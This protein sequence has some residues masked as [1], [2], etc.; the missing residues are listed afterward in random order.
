MTPNLARRFHAVNPPSAIVRRELAGGVA[1]RGASRH[2]YG[3]TRSGSQSF[4]PSQSPVV[5]PRRLSTSQVA[6]TNF[7]P[8]TAQGA[9]C[10]ALERVLAPYPMGLHGLREKRLERALRR[11]D[12]MGANSALRGHGA[13][14]G[15][16]CIGVAGRESAAHGVLQAV[17]DGVAHEKGA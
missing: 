9:L 6:V 13:A 11:L 14:V 2:R 5:I 7:K 16:P 17:C 12:A 4:N 15:A 1:L 8:R 10:K 3:S